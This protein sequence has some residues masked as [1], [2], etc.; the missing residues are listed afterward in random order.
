MPYFRIETNQRF[1][2]AE[3][4]EILKKAT[5]LIAEF[6]DKP[7]SWVMVS[8]QSDAEMMFGASENPTA[9]VELKSIGLPGDRC[10]VLADHICTFIENELGIP[11]D[12][13]FIDFK[14]LER[15]LFGWNKKT[16]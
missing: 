3:K 1:G 10:S 11:A 4:K 14:S 15:S 16:F 8:I 2:D 7:E 13:V 6:L 9:F 5:G 12:R